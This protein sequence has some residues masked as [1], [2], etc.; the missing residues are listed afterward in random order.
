MARLLEKYKEEII[1]QLRKDFNYANIMQV[2]KIEKIV[3]NM[4]VGE[5][6]QNIK[7][8]EIAEETLKIITGQKPVITKARRSIAGFKLREGNPIGCMVTLRGERMYEFL[9]RI[10]NVVLPRARDFKGISP[11]SFD[12]RGN[13]SMG[14]EEQS[15][16][17]E[18]NLDDIERMSVIVDQI[19]T[20][21]VE[22]SGA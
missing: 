2:P 11:N 14:L 20:Q 19:R 17:P 12:G 8:L 6:T 18:I 4:G 10:I 21:S 1:A 9:D 13:F 7:L 3:V 15:I 22:N 5:A 16:F